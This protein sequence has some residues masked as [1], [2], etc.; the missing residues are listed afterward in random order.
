MWRFVYLNSKIYKGELYA[1][2][3][4][5]CEQTKIYAKIQDYV[6]TLVTMKNIAPAL[7]V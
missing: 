2:D 4:N 5:Y 6:E 3:S 7:V 1:E